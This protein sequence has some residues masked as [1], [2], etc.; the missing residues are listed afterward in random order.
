M[1]LRLPLSRIRARRSAL[2]VLLAAVLSLPAPL[3]PLASAAELP[4]RPDVPGVKPTQVT[5]ASSPQAKAARAKVAKEKKANQ[6]L[7][8]SAAAERRAAVWPKPSASTTD[9]AGS[10]EDKTLVTVKAVKASTTSRQA[11]ALASGKAKVTVL[12]QKAA[13]RAGV[14]G[15]VFTVA[16][17]SPGAAQISVD[18]SSF[19]SAVGGNWSSRLGLVTLPACALTTPEKPHCRATTAQT[20]DN[21]VQ[22][23]TISSRTT[24]ASTSA[25]APTV[26]ALTAVSA[27]TSAAGAG[28]FKATPLAASASWQGG[29]SSGSFTWSYPITMPPAAAGPAPSLA[30]SYDSGSIDG[31]TANTNNQGSL[32]G[33]G[34][35]LTSSYIERKYGACEDDGQTDKYDLCWKYDNASIVLNGKATELVHN[36]GDTK[37]EWHLKDDDA[38]KVTRLKGADN[39][40]ADGEYWKVVTSDGTTYTFGLSKLSGA[41]S[42]RTDSVWTVPVFGDDDTEP[43]YDKGSEFKDR[44]QTQ[45]WRWNLDLVEDAHGNASTYWYAAETNYYAKNGDKTALASYTRGGYLKE[46]L[47]GQRSDT[48][49]TAPASDKVTFTYKERCTATDCSSLT[50]DTADNWPDVPFDTIC[51]A[52]EDDCNATGP[53]FFTRKRLT[54]I[55]TYFWSRAAE[56]DA[57]LPVDS[58]ALGQTFWDGQDIG[59]SSDQVL[60]LNSLTRTGKNG[61]A[62][63]VPPIEFTYQQRPNRVVGGTQPG[64]GDILDITRPRIASIISETGAMTSVTFSDPECVRGSNMPA[65]EDDNSLSCYPVYWPINGGDPQLDWFHKY[66]VTDVTTNDPGAGNPGTQLSYEYST[67]GWHYNDDPFTK[68]KERTWSIWR[69]YQKVTTY[70]GDPGTTRSKTVQLFMQ[71]MNGDKRKDGTTRTAVIKGIDLDNIAGNDPATTNDDLDVADATDND[72]YAGQLRQQI[73]YDGP[74]AIST[75]VNNI[76]AKQTASQQK[77]YAN[78]KAYFV[79]KARTYSDTYLTAAKKW[80]IAATSYTYDTTYGMATQVEDHGDWSASGDETCTRT[81]YARN[82]AK[83]LTAL[84]SRTRTVAKPCANTDDTLNLP[85][86][87]TARGDVL[88]DTAVVYDNPAATGWAPGQVPT[89]GLATWTGR[90]KA[91]PAASGTA[92]RNPLSATGWQTVTTTTYDT[93]AAKLGRP[94]TVTDAKG[95]ATTTTYYPAAAGP[96]TTQVVVQ[97]KLSSNN[98]AHQTV[99][100]YDPARGTESYTLD[101]NAKRTEYTY[102]SLGRVTATWLPDRSKSGGDSPDA[103]FGYGLE[104][105]KAPWTSVSTLKAGGTDYDTIYS[106]YDSQLRPIQT[107]SS[108]PLGGRTLTDTRYDSRGQAYESYADV[109]D[110]TTAPNGIYAQALYGGATQTQ[111]QFDGAGRATK[112]TLLVDGVKKWETATTYTGDSTATTGVQ[113][114]NATRTIIDA[115]GRTAETRTYAGTQPNDTTYGASTGTP[116]TSVRYTYTRDGKPDIVTG[117]DSAKWDYDYDL[118]G[119]QVK[120]ED[121]DKGTTTTSYTDL[122]QIDT[123]TDAKNRVLLY[124]YDELGRKTGLWQ[125]ERTEPNQL[126]A[127]TYDSVLKGQPTASI[128]Y[129]GGKTGKAYTKQVT[130][131][132]DLG[133]ATATSLTLPSDDPLVTSGAIAETSTFETTYRTD[134]TVGTIR[135]PAAA[136]LGSEI[137]E[138]R[139]NS[140]GLPN[141]LS[142]KSGYLLAADYTAL[143]QVGQLQLGTSTASGTKRVF[144]TNTY[145]RGTGRLLSAAVD[146]QTRGPVQDLTYTYDQ[147]GNATSITDSADI[148]TGADNQCFTYDAYRRLTEAW[149]PKTPDC[150]TS[151]RT[152]ANL[153][154]PAPYWTSYTYTASGQRQTEKQNTGAPVTTTYCYDGTR[155]HALTATTTTGNCTG[156]TPQYTYDATG[157]T[158]KRVRTAGS[159][160]KQTLSWNEEG[161]LVGLTDDAAATSTNYLYDADGEL[162]IRRNNATDGET[163][164]YLGA[165]EV[166]LKTG[167]KWANRYYS[168]AGAT[169]ALR[170]NE[171]STEKLSFLASDRNGTSSIAIT[172]DSAQTLSKRYSTPFGANRGQMTGVWPDDKAFLGMSVDAATG[173]TH[174][175]AREYDPSTGQFINVD[176]LLQL[177]LHQTLNGYSYGM[178][179]PGT[180]SDPSGQ[181][182]ACGVGHEDDCPTNDSNGDGVILP[183]DRG[184]DYNPGPITWEDEGPQGKDLDKDGYITLLPGVYI[185]AEWSGT[186]EFIQHFYS[187]LEELGTIYGLEFYLDNPEAPIARADVSHA[188][189][190]ACHKSG[191]PDKKQFFVNWFG[192]NVAASM[193][194][195]GIGGR[196]PGL[197]SLLNGKKSPSC[198]C[199]LAGTDVLMADGTTKDIEDIQVGDEVLAADPETGK[200]SPHK[201]T[202]LIR[203]DDDKEFNEISMATQEGVEQLTAT[204]EHPFWSP[205]E[206]RWVEA[207]YF[208]PGMTLLTG[209]GSAVIVTGNR[210]F[211][212]H[213]RAYNLT[214][215]G[216]HTYYVLAGETPVLVHN[217]NCGVGDALKGWQTRYFQMGDQHLRLTKERMQHILERHH[218]SYRKGSDKATQTNFRKNMSIQDVEDAISGVVQQNRGMISSRGVNDTYQVEG[219]YGG[220]TYTMGISNG[221]IGQFYPH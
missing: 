60:T 124:D 191:C 55:D 170:T 105:D 173:L 25:A 50:E 186:G 198:K 84:V 100:L 216:L 121:P 86:S 35:D 209:D 125:D 175:G 8:E 147:A 176:P 177:D 29:S 195:G 18:Y 54:S 153:G 158:E 38:S 88:S 97:P 163:V 171:T 210:K 1:S 103:K 188:L 206:K 24:L 150:A 180:F 127:W 82:D 156:L 27:T 57:F 30:L 83:G 34:F 139:Y 143:A 140:A 20:S 119:R 152:T 199:F 208:K 189:L 74:I 85:A 213:A 204:H 46:I 76:W 48:L 47:Y 91:Y 39:G 87:S 44:A 138:Y 201:V 61:T 146:D 41:G 142:G 96:L 145:E 120:A 64:G 220:V 5:E 166:H 56:P 33:E 111:T 71:G 160:T 109:W 72:Y 15:L 67:P 40:D 19:A 26:M 187:Q 94:L 21:D 4:G 16:A 141:E 113:G 123:T 12:D 137:L 13:R 132:D 14:T 129:E 205:S 110:S 106:L 22:A 116:Y 81:W 164:L 6:R 207:G 31:R 215:E 211:I 151:G 130:A 181:G 212:K 131:Y 17:D 28:D 10:P 77:S 101:I 45:A 108:S 174:V 3:T 69:G 169:I 182:I 89:L 128:R 107:Q 197:R 203:T 51:S 118:F 11:R 95:R 62:I 78:I 161:R 193:S 80:R 149:T 155:T 168:A 66:R 190:D 217:S 135:E 9:L 52:D 200:Q 218:P 133:R 179:N 136:G 73:T 214:I 58:Y 115:L 63:A 134:G 167:K 196:G 99:T 42:E 37:D 68:E 202:R 221:R 43:G 154:G 157:N 90:A 53:A 126:A 92:D 70:T 122:D 36:D 194:E 117:P 183:E 23:Q 32:V 112:S 7:V 192:V 219:V 79:N 2:T 144:L 148:G 75:T 185:P 165:T 98:Q 104:R 59:N 162:L 184:S 178:Q 172:S 93:A 114:G 102:D 159:T 49:F 65:A